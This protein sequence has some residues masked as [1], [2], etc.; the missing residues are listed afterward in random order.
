MA[1]LAEALAVSAT[2]VARVA[3]GRS[4]TVDAEHLEIEAARASRPAVT[5][6]CYGTLRRYGRSQAIV[7]A[8]S[9]HA[10]AADPLVESLLWCALYA[11]ESG[12]YADYTVVD[13][14]ANACLALRRAQAK[15]YVNALLRQFLRTRGG[16]E[17]RIGASPPARYW[18]PAWWIERLRRAYPSEWESV[19]A[20]GNSHPP[21]CLR[22]NLRRVPLASYAERLATEGIRVRPVGPA[23]LL[24]EKPLP[25]DRLPGFAQGEVS[26][27][28]AGGQR[29]VALLDLRPGQRVL[30]ACAAP[31]GKSAHML[32]SSDIELTALDIDEARC[33]DVTRNLAR[34]GLVALVRTADCATPESW[35][36]GRLFDRVLADVPCS[37]SG[38]AR[39]HP[40]I[41]WLRRD[42][43]VEG[44]AVRQTRILES[45]WR[46]LAPGGK[47]L[48][49]TCSVFPE[50]NDAV[51]D[52]FAARTPGVRRVA[53]PNGAAAQLL[54]G[55]EHDGFFFAQL[56]KTA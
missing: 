31:G 1:P 22:V 30:D 32:E 41:K 7:R 20:S 40:D 16:I 8:L 44:F 33:G 14:A 18:H 12:R 53:L 13:Q 38:V 43:D 27:Q 51:V 55:P 4:L 9:K 26:V 42:A 39:R 34:L 46:V 25:V 15:P 52:A 24:L 2:L 29:A 50:E 37:A 56:E 36:D 21:M 19:L 11:L 48:Y 47:L 28:D 10:A 35:R 49:V 54:P 3:S 17:S 5:D 23:A 45:L 6:L